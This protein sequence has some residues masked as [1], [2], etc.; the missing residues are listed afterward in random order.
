MS[1]EPQRSGSSEDNGLHEVEQ[2]SGD[3][4]AQGPED[5]VRDGLEARERL[6]PQQTFDLLLEE[7]KEKLPKNWDELN[8]SQQL[9]WFAHRMLLDQREAI[10]IEHGNEAARDTGFLSDYQLERRRRR[11]VHSKLDSWDEVPPR[12]GI[13]SRTYVDKNTLLTGRKAE[14]GPPNPGV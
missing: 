1:R 12:Q 11:E 8:Y 9:E 6:S 2:P 5:P 13:F 7:Y 10:R 4:Q 14:D 3:V